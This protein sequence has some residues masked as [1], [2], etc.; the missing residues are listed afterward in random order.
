MMRAATCNDVLYDPLPFP[1]PQVPLEESSCLFASSARSK[2]V[3]ISGHA[4]W[5]SE[6]FLLLVKVDHKGEL[7]DGTFVFMG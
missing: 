4:A 3:G 6:G 1:D 7:T 5:L 2:A